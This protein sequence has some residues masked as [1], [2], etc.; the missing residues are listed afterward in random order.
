VLRGGLGV[1]MGCLR[2]RATVPAKGLG[3]EMKEASGYQ[4]MV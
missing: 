4:L 3:Q 2:V 1:A